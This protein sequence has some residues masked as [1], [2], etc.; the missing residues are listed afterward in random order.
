MLGERANAELGGF[1]RRMGHLAAAI[2]G[3]LVFGTAGLS[4][5]EDVDVW[6][7]LTWSLDTIATIGSIPAPETT[8]GQSVKIVL[9]V[10]GVG[11]LFYALVSVTEFFVAGHLGNLLSERRLQRMTDALTDHTIICGFGR[12]GRQVARDLEVAGSRYVVIDS[13]PGTMQVAQDAGVHAI[14]GSAS[15][16]DVLRR[17]GIDRARA[18]VTCVD[19]DAENI[20]VTLTAR[21]LRGDDLLVV[22]R[23]SEEGSEK[24]LRRA[25][26]DRVISPYKSSGAEMAR[27]ARHPQVSGVVDVSAEYRLEEI[28]VV[29]GCEGAG[30]RVDDVSHE[31]I[32]IGLRREGQ[33]V[34]G[35]AGETVLQAGDVI[36]AM[37]PAPAMD[38]LEGLFDPEGDES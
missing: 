24:K 7:A 20:F 25:G 27:L 34:P 36:V 16:D 32:V 13:D 5:T 38:R 29:E 14:V 11:T 17:A 28:D 9:V 12:V 4:I 3:L 10:A 19:S 21:E 31:S 18:I 26:A 23:A 22:A 33:F 35:P 15:D 2:V 30:R 37:G 1:M 6:E 8:G